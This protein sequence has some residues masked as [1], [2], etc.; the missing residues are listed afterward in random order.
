MPA[1]GLVRGAEDQQQQHQQ[2]HLQALLSVVVQLWNVVS[3]GL[4]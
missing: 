2:M 1:M 3:W 4:S